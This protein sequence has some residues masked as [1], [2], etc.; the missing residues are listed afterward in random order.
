MLD[1]IENIDSTL[2][3]KIL[4]GSLFRVIKIKSDTRR[5]K[6]IKKM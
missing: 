5:K 4:V 3:T 1:G 6:R 2:E